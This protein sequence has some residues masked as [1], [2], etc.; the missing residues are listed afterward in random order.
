MLP[1][2]L[3]LPQTKLIALSYYVSVQETNDRKKHTIFKSLD[4]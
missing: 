1:G 3:T 4:S 2:S